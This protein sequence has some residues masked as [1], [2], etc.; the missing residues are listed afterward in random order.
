VPAL[1]AL[2]VADR[3]LGVSV[4]PGGDALHVTP[5]VHDA[6]ALMEAV[7]VEVAPVFTVAGLALTATPL[8]THVV[9]PEGELVVPLDP[10]ANAKTDAIML[11]A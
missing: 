7:T 2:K 5:P 10:H 1:A 9:E 3:P 8:T 6:P 4:P 11:T